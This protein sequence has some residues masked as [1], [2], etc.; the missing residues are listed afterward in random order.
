MNIDK[1]RNFVEVVKYGSIT[2]AAKGIYISQTALSQ[3]IVS[4]EAE[5]GVTLFL[6][7]PNKTELTTAGRVFY[8]ECTKIISIYDNAVL[9]TQEAAEQNKGN[10]TIGIN[11]EHEQHLPFVNILN[12]FR[13]KYS[14]TEVNFINST[15]LDMGRKLENDL[16]DC[17][18]TYADDITFFKSIE[19]NILFEDK[20]GLLVPLNHPYAQVKEIPAGEV[21]SEKI[22]MISQQAGPLNYKRMIESCK[23]DGYEPNIVAIA[24]N[25]TSLLMFVELGICSV[26]IPQY[27][28]INYTKG[29]FVQLINSNHKIEYI[30]AWNRD[31]EKTQKYQY[32]K[33]FYKIAQKHLKDKTAE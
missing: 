7:R 14:E 17:A 16:I 21:A 20:I 3:Q 9:K 25:I 33:S 4:M 27:F 12:E 19:Y 5:L 10:F 26:L 31:I 2:R 24:D 1:M 28:C 8:E 30:M 6:R 11:V 15:F 23:L 29:H 32:V 13:E 18:L 22:G